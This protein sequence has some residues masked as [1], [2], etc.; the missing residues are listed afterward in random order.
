[1][2]AKIIPVPV[3]SVNSA[4]NPNSGPDFKPAVHLFGIPPI[5]HP[6]FKPGVRNLIPNRILILQQEKLGHWHK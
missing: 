4:G 1:M 2:C 5:A 6:D 3:S